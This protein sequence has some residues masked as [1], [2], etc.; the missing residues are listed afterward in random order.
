[1]NITSQDLTSFG[2]N[3]VYGDM[4]NGAVI[5]KSGAGVLQIT[6]DNRTFGGLFLQSNGTTAVS[7]DSYF[8]ETSISSI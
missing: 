7:A 8:G 5:E 1:M 3:Q 4:A 2:A 6:G